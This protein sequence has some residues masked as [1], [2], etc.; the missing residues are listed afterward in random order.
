MA[1]GS[2]LF[3]I[4]SMWGQSEEALSSSI[5]S[6]L[7]LCFNGVYDVGDRVSIIKGIHLSNISTRAHTD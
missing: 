5:V 3:S 4:T 6:V 7:T 1:V 2:A